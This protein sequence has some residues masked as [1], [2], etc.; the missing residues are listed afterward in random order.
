M[1]SSC[2]KSLHGNLWVKPHEMRDHLNALIW[3]SRRSCQW[4]FEDVENFMQQDMP[5]CRHCQYV[6][7]EVSFKPA[8]RLHAANNPI[9]PPPPGPP[10]R[11]RSPKRSHELEEKEEDEYEQAPPATGGGA[12]TFPTM[13][14]P[15][16]HGPCHPATGGFL[17]AVAA[18]EAAASLQPLKVVNFGFTHD[19]DSDPEIRPL[20]GTRPWYL[21]SSVQMYIRGY[22]KYLVPAS[23]SRGW[24]VPATGCVNLAS[25]RSGA[26]FTDTVANRQRTLWEAAEDDKARWALRMTLL[27]DDARGLALQITHRH[28]AYYRFSDGCYYFWKQGELMGRLPD[29][30]RPACHDAGGPRV[31]G[32]CPGALRAQA[33][34]DL[35]LEAADAEAMVTSEEVR[36]MNVAK[37][38]LPYLNGMSKVDREQWILNNAMPTRACSRPDSVSDRSPKRRQAPPATGG[39]ACTSP[40]MCVRPAAG[41]PASHGPVIEPPLETWSL[42]Q[43]GV[44][45]SETSIEP[46]AG[47]AAAS[48]RRLSLDELQRLD[49]DDSDSDLSD[50]R[51]YVKYRHDLNY[52]NFHSSRRVLNQDVKYLVPATVIEWDSRGSESDPGGAQPATGGTQPATPNATAIQH[53]RAAFDDTVANRQRTLWEAAQDDKASCTLRTTLR[54]EKT[55]RSAPLSPRDGPYYRFSD[56]CYYFW[57]QGELVG[58]LPDAWRPTRHAAAADAEAAAVTALS[59]EQAAVTDA[60]VWA[61]T[62]AKNILPYLDGMSKV[63]REQWIANDAYPP[64]TPHRPDSGSS[65]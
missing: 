24:L 37:G 41:P 57:R 44:P 46:A 2:H 18:G 50:T 25:Q 32:A 1:H 34:Q 16:S 30:W 38:I 6:C 39:G 56:G 55:R 48:S 60:E 21:T 7:V 15:A 31:R 19:D 22:V 36:A 63:G 23:V 20:P 5:Q 61:T 29:A 33:V 11:S 10:S 58:R 28:G 40:T 12:C 4:A 27:C 52:Y 49:Y 62:V 47:E 14:L 42:I 59:G 8:S 65:E 26:S 51:G 3:Q 45:Y 13:F 9:H 35:A 64:R 53:S 43:P 54:P 17:A